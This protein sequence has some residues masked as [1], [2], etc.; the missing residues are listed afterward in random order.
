MARALLGAWHAPALVSAVSIDAAAKNV[1]RAERARVSDLAVGD[2]LTWSSLEGSLPFAW[3]TAKDPALP[4]AVECSDVLE[5]L[6]Q[7]T[8]RVTG[9]A[10]GEYMLKIDGRKVAV[11]SREQLA[12]GVNL[13]TLATPMRAQALAIHA[14]TLRHADV[15]QFRW[16]QLQVPMTKDAYPSMPRAI[17]ALDALEEEIVRQQRER[18]K[19]EPHKFELVPAG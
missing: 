8:L 13:A 5:A 11:L 15:H 7:E 14:L 2:R 12:A 10:A 18:A 6:D 16:R 17:E 3:D 19:P 1:E 4:L 9:L